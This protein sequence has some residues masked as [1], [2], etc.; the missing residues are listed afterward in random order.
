[1]TVCLHTYFPTKKKKKALHTNS[2]M[3][4]S[5]PSFT[6]GELSDSGWRS[7]WL[8]DEWVDGKEIE[9]VGVSAIRK[10]SGWATESESESV[11]DRE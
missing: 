1:M 3:R 6:G 11:S 8:A 9:S 7:E 10:L 5:T 4:C 2:E